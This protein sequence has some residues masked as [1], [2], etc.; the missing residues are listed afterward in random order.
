MTCRRRRPTGL[1][2]LRCTVGL[3]ATVKLRPEPHA[4]QPYSGTMHMVASPA[5]RGIASV[6]QRRDFGGGFS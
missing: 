2:E 4:D 3:P 5:R 6:R 1:P